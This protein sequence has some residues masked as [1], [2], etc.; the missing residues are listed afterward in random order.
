M[1]KK[2]LAVAVFAI[3]VVPGVASAQSFTFTLNGSSYPQFGSISFSGFGNGV[4]GGSPFVVTDLN[5]T[6]NSP[7]FGAGTT[8]IIGVTNFNGADNVISFNTPQIVSTAGL[9][10]L[11]VGAGEL[12]LRFNSLNSTVELFS[13]LQ[14]GGPVGTI[15][16]GTVAQIAAVPGPVAGAGLVPLLGFAGVWFARRRKRVAA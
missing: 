14:A 13:S 9:S 3:M 4:G 6:L 7:G 16:S 8:A 5:G 11:T 12:N 1:F 2:L 10:F 15:T